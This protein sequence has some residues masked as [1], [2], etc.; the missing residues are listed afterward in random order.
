MKPPAPA[1]PIGPAPPR[2]PGSVRRTSTI[3][4]S[5]PEGP[6]EPTLVRGHARDLH[7]DADGSA[8]VLAEDRYTIRSSADRRIL[9]IT[10]D[11]WRAVAGLAGVRGGGHLR[12]ALAKV[13]PAERADGTPLY[14]LLDDFSGASLVAGWAWSCWS[15]ERT[16]QERQRQAAAAAGRR[17]KM[18]GVCAGFRPG[19]TALLDDGTPDSTIQSN[20]RVGPLMRAE[21]PIGWHELPVQSGVGMRRARRIDAWLDDVIHIDAGFQDS[22]TSP[23]GGRIAIHEYQV[24]A[25]ADP[26]SFRLLSV[27]ADPRILPYGECLA[28]AANVSRIVGTVLGDLRLAVVETFPRVLGCTHLNDVL[29]SLAEVPQMLAE[30][31]RIARDL[32]DIP[33]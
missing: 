11:P 8:R 30:P 9:E 5:W 2:R 17:G 28:A 23:D 14:L 24:S 20:A 15:D 1:R 26:I 3:D 22:A 4:T 10:T 31:D 6:S 32:P 25:I 12:E 27:E 19:S 13:L 18:V 29:R 33:R 21:D 7:T 16:R